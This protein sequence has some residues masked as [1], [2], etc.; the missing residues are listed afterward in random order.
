M[1][2]VCY[3]QQASKESLQSLHL[4]AWRQTVP[5]LLLEHHLIFDPREMQRQKV[6]THLLK[7][8]SI[9]LLMEVLALE[10][11][12]KVLEL[13]LVLEIDCLCQLQ[14]ASKRR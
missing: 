13:L 2:W 12:V 7:S 6:S 10:L 11:K 8:D 9:R 14:E 4:Q 5:L 3:C 1:D